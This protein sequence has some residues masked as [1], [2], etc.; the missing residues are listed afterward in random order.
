MLKW[1]L[2]QEKKK[3]KVEW[4]KKK[5]RAFPSKSKVYCNKINDDANMHKACCENHD[6]NNQNKQ[7]ITLNAKTYESQNETSTKG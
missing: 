6:K 1:S 2:T 5:V 4:E 3:Q 7:T